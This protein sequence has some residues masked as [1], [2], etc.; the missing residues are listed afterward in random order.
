MHFGRKITLIY[1]IATH[2]IEKTLVEKDLET[3]LS[4]NLELVSHKKQEFIFKHKMKK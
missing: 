3:I 1:N 4:N 2:R